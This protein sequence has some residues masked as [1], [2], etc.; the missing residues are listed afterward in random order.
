MGAAQVTLPPHPSV[1]GIPKL[2]EGLNLAR[3]KG[4]ALSGWSRH[5]YQL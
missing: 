5:I 2:I 1:E 4:R 3:K